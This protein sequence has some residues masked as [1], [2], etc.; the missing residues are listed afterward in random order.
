LT[1][2]SQTSGI[3]LASTSQSGVNV[4][5]RLTPPFSSRARTRNSVAAS[6]VTR[7]PFLS[8]MSPLFIEMPPPL[9]RRHMPPENDESEIVSKQHICRGPATIGT[10]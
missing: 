10:R 5:T 2:F 3:A 9:S 4:R 8:R 7:E 1:S 6:S